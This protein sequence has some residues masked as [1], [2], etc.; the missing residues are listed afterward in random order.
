M[1][2]CLKKCTSVAPIAKCPYKLIVQNA[3]RLH[4]YNSSPLYSLEYLI[5]SDH[6]PFVV[7]VEK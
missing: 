4:V 7:Y 5:E 1:K 6:D 3:M 2:K